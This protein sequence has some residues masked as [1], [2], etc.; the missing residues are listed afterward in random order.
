MGG[1]FHKQQKTP[2]GSERR[3]NLSREEDHSSSLYS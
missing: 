3:V 1:T 2:E